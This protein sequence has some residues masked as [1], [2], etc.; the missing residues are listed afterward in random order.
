MMGV[1]ET[2]ARTRTRILIRITNSVQAFSTSPAPPWL[3]AIFS[4]RGEK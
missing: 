2:V 3:D 4:S 1:E